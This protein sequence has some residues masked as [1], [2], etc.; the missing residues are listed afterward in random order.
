MTKVELDNGHLH[1]AKYG[2][3][4][5]ILLAFHGFGQ[6]KNIFLPWSKILGEKYTIYA[7]DLFYHGKSERKYG[8]LS[9][10]EWKAYM[11]KFIEQEN[12]ESF[13]VLGYSL[14]GR[15][16]IST[17]LSFPNKT[18]KLTLIATD[19]IF[20]TIWFKLATTPV[21]RL[22]WK[23]LMVNPD[24][25]EKWIAFNDRNKI[26]N[27]YV[28]DFVRKEMGTAENRKR[29]Y[30]SWNHFKTLGYS[31]RQL[32]KQFNKHPFERQI[33]LGSKDHIIRAKDILPII[34]K[35]G[36]FK[37]EILPKKHHQLMSIDV[38]K[39]LLK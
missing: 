26:I 13:S 20:K 37:I 1:Y 33:I 16:A 4:N 22:I 7:F 34:H 11:L 10:K 15:F 38:A 21:I 2:S 36:N 5:E 12:I 3:G 35:M 39:L 8:P 18:K 31:K 29:V 14:G 23:Y 24:K 19:G 32:V 9:K 17:T 6:D 28:A 27:K 25:L 30:I